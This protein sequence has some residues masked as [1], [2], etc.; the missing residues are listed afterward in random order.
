MHNKALQNKN[1]PL[2]RMTWVRILIVLQLSLLAWEFYPDLSTNGDDARY[3]LL[4][5]SL[6]HGTGYRQIQ[7]PDAPVETTYPIAF[8]LMLSFVEV[9]SGNIMLAKMILALCGALVT[10]LCFHFFRRYSG[11]LLMPLV[12]L[13][14]VSCLLVEYSSSLMSEIPYLLF[15]LLA[16]ICYDRSVDNPK[17]RML[18]WTA[19]VLSVIPMHCRSVG[20]AFSAAWIVQ[21][22]LT[23]RHRYLFAHVGLVLVTV[24]AFHVL[25]TWDNSYLL[26]LVQ[27]NSYNPDL[28]LVSLHDMAIRIAQNCKSYGLLITSQATVPIPYVLPLPVRYCI[29]MVLLA[30]ILIGWLRSLMGTMRFLSVYLFLYFC[31]LLLWQAQWSSERFLVGI[32]P[33]LYLFLL[34][35]IDTLLLFLKLAKGKSWRAWSDIPGST[36]SPPSKA[37]QTVVWAITGLICAFN[38]FSQPADLHLKRNPGKDWNYFYSCADWIR[39]NTPA[40]AVVMS[41]KPELFYVRSKRAG[42][43]YPFTHNVEKVM[44]EIDKQHVTHV[45]MDNF[46]WTATSLEYLYPAI[47]SH[48]DRFRVV[49]S[50]QNP[51]FIVYE[52]INQ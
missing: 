20:L 17:N 3:Y 23:R 1:T 38:V 28:G 47:S 19:I 12:T 51:P 6:A 22:V 49:Y 16:L 40:T 33:F 43:I 48:M 52:V 34:R 2:T 21:N 5:A 27:K 11:R 50:L 35:G 15:S 29:S 13:C 30:V 45:V 46:A 31:I 39:I 18:F 37:S 42:V 8:P 14:A 36:A 7:L 9:L 4:G 41:R 24:I 26:Q 44:E 25:T 10:F 32:L